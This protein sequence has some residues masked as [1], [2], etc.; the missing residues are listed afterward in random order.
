MKKIIL[1]LSLI[2]IFINSSGQWY[3]DRYG[4]ERID[5]LTPE[6]YTDAL[7]HCNNTAVT[8]GV[9]ALLGGG[10]LLAG[11]LY[12]NK[13]LGEDPSFLEELVGAEGMGNILLGLGSVLGVTGTITGITGLIRTSSVRSAQNRYSTGYSIEFKPSVFYTRSTAS[14]ATGITLIMIF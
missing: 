11:F 7:E 3:K 1:S 13:G 10:S 8:G 5:L 2:I 9:L 12:K 14:S 4:V 6:Q